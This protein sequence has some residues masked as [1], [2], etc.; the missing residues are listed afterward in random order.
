MFIENNLFKWFFKHAKDVGK[1][2]YEWKE[3]K[4]KNK[5]VEDIKMHRT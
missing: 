2:I 4:D 3:I 1:N 5:Q